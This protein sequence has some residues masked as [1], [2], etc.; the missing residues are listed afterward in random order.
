[1]T[2]QNLGSQIRRYVNRPRRLDGSEPLP[3]AAWQDCS[4]APSRAFR[5]HRRISNTPSARCNTS[6]ASIRPPASAPRQVGL[7]EREVGDQ[8]VVADRLRKLVETRSASVRRMAAIGLRRARDCV[9]DPHSPR[10]AVAP[11]EL[12]EVAGGDRQDMGPW[13]RLRCVRRWARVEAGLS[14]CCRAERKASS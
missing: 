7:R 2:L 13:K 11:M 12:C 8:I 3:A 1:M 10:R 5:P 14:G 6:N 9:E 4:R